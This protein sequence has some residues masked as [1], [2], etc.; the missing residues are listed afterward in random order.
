MSYQ[1]SLATTI[2]W[3][4][5]IINLDS[6]ANDAHPPKFGFLS[7]LVMEDMTYQSS[8]VYF[9][10][11]ASGNCWQPL[12]L[13]RRLSVCGMIM[14]LLAF[15]RCHKNQ[16]LVWPPLCCC[17]IPYKNDKEPCRIC[18]CWP[19]LSWGFVSILLE[20]FQKSKDKADHFLIFQW[21]LLHHLVLKIKS[22]F[23][24]PSMFLQNTSI[25]SLECIVG[26]SKLGLEKHGRPCYFDTF[27]S[28][29]LLFLL[30]NSHWFKCFATKH[31]IYMFESG[32][33][34]TWQGGYFLL[35]RLRHRFS[36]Y[37]LIVNW[38]DP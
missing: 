28:K 11:Q 16:P 38:K 15:L 13:T 6:N 10:R 35:M 2:T 14:L 20:W 19:V 5:I 18:K 37:S 24:M 34:K 1:S 32:N 36:L 12:I 33:E 21:F 30:K 25:I 9:I 31:L 23:S 22:F 8:A 3:N 26:T 7:H 17:R 4:T 27:P 29:W